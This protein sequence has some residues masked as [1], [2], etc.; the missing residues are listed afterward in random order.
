LGT[1]P[2]YGDFR[3]GI[4]EA[5]KMSEVIAG[6]LGGVVLIAVILMVTERVMTVFL[7]AAD[8]AQGF[9]RE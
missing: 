7:D 5:E 9:F 1:I 8:I 3:I 4:G 2:L 6:L